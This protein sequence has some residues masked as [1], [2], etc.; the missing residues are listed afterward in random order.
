VAGW[1]ETSGEVD[2][3]KYYSNQWLLRK[4]I[5]SVKLLCKLVVSGLMETSNEKLRERFSER[6]RGEL[7]RMGVPVSSPTQI[8]REFNDRYPATTITAQTV[9]KWLFAEAIPT[10]AKLL[11][12]AEWFEVSPQWLRFG[13][14]RRRQQPTRDV[15]PPEGNPS[16]LV[17]GASQPTLVPLLELL[18]RLTPANLRLVE[19][20]IRCVLAEQ[21]NGG[22]TN[23]S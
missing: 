18:T 4:P 16:I 6:L 14:G 8:A 10:Q 22:H 17:I 21:L 12:L 13:T 7:G 15:V 2:F 9:R 23:I 19:G 20:L 3:G 11:L 1:A 5:S